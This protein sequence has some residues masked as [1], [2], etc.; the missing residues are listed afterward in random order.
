MRQVPQLADRQESGMGASC[1]SQR[2]TSLASSGA[3]ISMIRPVLDSVITLTIL[4]MRLA[5]QNNVSLSIAYDH[6]PAV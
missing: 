2:S 5:R 3:S 6:I 1:S 4:L